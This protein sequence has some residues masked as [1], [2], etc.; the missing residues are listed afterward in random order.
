MGNRPVRSTRAARSVRTRQRLPQSPG[1]PATGA[2]VL[3][4]GGAANGE[5]GQ[6]AADRIAAATGATA[7]VETF[8]A[9]HTRGA[10][11]PALDRLGYLAEGRRWRNSGV[12]T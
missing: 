8:P 5:A 2:R 4:I 1:V 11:V 10:G 3:L 7:L 9:R 6:R 12:N